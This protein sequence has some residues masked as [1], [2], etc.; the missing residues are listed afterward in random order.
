MQVQGT[1]KSISQ[2]QTHGNNGF[3]KREVIVETSEQYPQTLPI[4]FVQD[5]TSILENF[6][7]GQSVKVSI[8]LRG[9]E[10]ISPSGEVKHFI[11]LQGWKIEAV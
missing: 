3:Q 11:S 1:I 10:W 7:E 5:K 8:N 6:Q 4:E 9:K 2:T